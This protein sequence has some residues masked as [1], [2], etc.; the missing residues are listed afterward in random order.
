M[1]NPFQAMQAFRNPSQFL[2]QQLQ[3]RMSQ[4]MKQNPQAFQ[5]MQEMTSGKS[6][7][8]MKQTAMNLAQQQGIDL[9]S[10]A[11]N[12]GINI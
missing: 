8:E 4:M 1:I 7:T 3:T 6:E 5:K 12:F 11:S 9:K 10:F 2:S